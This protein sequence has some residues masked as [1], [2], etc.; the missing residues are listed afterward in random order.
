M[1]GRLQISIVIPM[2]NEEANVGKLF[3]RLFPVME[4]LGE[5]YE[6]IAIDDGSTDQTAK[7]LADAQERHAQLVVVTLGKNYG[8]HAAV[9]AGF[10]TSEGEWVVTLDA[11]LQ[12][13]PEEIPKLIDAFRKGHDVVNTIRQDRNDT[14]FRR[15]ASRIVNALARRASGIQLNDFGCMLRGYHRDLLGPM[16]ERKEFETFIPALAMVYA[17]N[18]V[19]I[20][21]GHA[22]REAGDSKYSLIRL[23]SLQL[24][25]VMSFSLL[26]IRLLFLLG[27]GIALAGM[28]FGA[29]LLFL[30]LLM[31]PEWAAGGVFTLFAIMFF[32]VGAQFVALGLIGEYVGRV[33][34]EVRQRP[35]YL[36]RSVSRAQRQPDAEPGEVVRPSGNDL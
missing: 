27:V 16:V 25:L 21:V 18:P 26:P 9:M 24:D 15:S 12:N 34:Y 14:Y 28:G 11:D 1:A 36:V 17:C 4:A 23:F 35:T 5:P 2:L 3:A 13:P 6:V 20:E 10:E 7:H 30:R 32:F 8:Q 29:L 19:E 22:A 33:Y 31:G